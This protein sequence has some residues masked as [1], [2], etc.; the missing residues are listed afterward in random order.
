MFEHSI[1]GYL[2]P[3]AV[4]P[5]LTKLLIHRNARGLETSIPISIGS[6]LAISIECFRA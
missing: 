2:S 5:L 6:C 4:W 1:P 3:Q